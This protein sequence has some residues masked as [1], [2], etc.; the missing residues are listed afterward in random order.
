M[1]FRGFFLQNLY[2]P[3]AKLFL[4]E[5]K[6]DVRVMRNNHDDFFRQGFSMG[7]NRAWI[8]C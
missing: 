4:N 7:Q 3:S 2:L 1:Q 5:K 8:S 6:N